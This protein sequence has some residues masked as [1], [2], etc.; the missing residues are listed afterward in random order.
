MIQQAFRLEYSTLVWMVIE[1]AVR[2]TAVQIP[3]H[4]RQG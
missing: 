1:A 4:R 2:R 3:D